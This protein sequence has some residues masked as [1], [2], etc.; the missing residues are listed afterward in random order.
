MKLEWTHNRNYGNLF[1][2]QNIADLRLY[3]LISIVSMLLAL[4]QHTPI[5][6]ETLLKTVNKTWHC[7]K[8]VSYIYLKSKNRLKAKIHD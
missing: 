7:N 2:K 4:L 1:R 6:Y 3:T 8:I 5:I